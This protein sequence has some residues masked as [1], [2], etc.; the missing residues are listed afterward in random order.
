MSNSVYK[1]LPPASPTAPQALT[2]SVYMD[3]SVLLGGQC[4]NYTLLNWTLPMSTGGVGVLLSYYTMY[5]T[6]A[7]TTTPT[8]YPGNTTGVLMTS[9]IFGASYQ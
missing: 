2:V 3:C 5:L 1:L 9:L 7:G 4:V 6:Y 8:Q